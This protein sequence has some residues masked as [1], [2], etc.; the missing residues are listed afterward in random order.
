MADVLL[1]VKHG[2]VCRRYSRYKHV[3][4]GMNIKRRKRPSVPGLYGSVSTTQ[5]P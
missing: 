2:V 4:R 5:I 1:S 3:G